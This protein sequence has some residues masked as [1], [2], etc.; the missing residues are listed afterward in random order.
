MGTILTQFLEDGLAQKQRFRYRTSIQVS[1]GPHQPG[2]TF[3]AHS[4]LEYHYTYA[5][6]TYM[7][8]FLMG[9]PMSHPVSF[10]CL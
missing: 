5:Y 6:T 10:L 9:D 3:G 4:C 8:V 1:R 2:N 7:S